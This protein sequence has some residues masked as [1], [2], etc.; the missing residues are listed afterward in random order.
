MKTAEQ[1]ARLSHKSYRKYASIIDLLRLYLEHYGPRVEVMWWS[2]RDRW[3]QIGDFGP[4]L[5]P[6]DE[7][8]DYVARDP[9]GCFW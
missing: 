6:L 8:L 3:D 4:M 2:H 7:A 9:M 1:K 5:M